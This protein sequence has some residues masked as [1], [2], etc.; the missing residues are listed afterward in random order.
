MAEVISR[1]L[2]DDIE[3]AEGREVEADAG[4]LAYALDGTEYEI[5]LCAKNAADFRTDMGKYIVHSRKVHRAVRKRTRVQSP[6]SA[7]K[8]DFPLSSS[9]PNP[10]KTATPLKGYD[11][12]QRRAIRHWAR[13]NGHPELSDKG[14]LP[15]GIV[16]EFENAG[17]LT[18][19]PRFSG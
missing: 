3:K 13:R 10:P 8:T 6:A 18:L 5:D 15:D 2:V 1:R 7:P 16:V 19:M 12:E 9:T 11:K 4:T 14:P 17:G